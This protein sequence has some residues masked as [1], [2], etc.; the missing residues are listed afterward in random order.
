MPH[1]R[2][3]SSDRLQASILAESG[4]GCPCHKPHDLQG[5]CANMAEW[6]KCYN[7]Q[8]R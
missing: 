6:T 8:L 3:T 5:N 7:G 2:L 1:A 4:Y